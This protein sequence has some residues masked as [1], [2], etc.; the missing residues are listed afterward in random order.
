VI[1]DSGVR[2]RKESII[3]TDREKERAERGVDSVTDYVEAKEIGDSEK[4]KASLAAL[5]TVAE[6]TTTAA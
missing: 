4:A 6:T 3:M 5:A 1:L 2:Y